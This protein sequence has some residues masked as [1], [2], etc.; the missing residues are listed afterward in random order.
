MAVPQNAYYRVK[1]RSFETAPTLWGHSLGNKVVKRLQY[2]KRSG[3]VKYCCPESA[4]GYRA[5]YRAVPERI[6][7]GLRRQHNRMVSELKT[8]RK[9]KRRAANTANAL[10]K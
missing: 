8:K 6:D 9:R 10:R 5:F 7:D 2:Q 1:P 4:K 3:N